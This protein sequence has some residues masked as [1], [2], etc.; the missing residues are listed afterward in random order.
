MLSAVRRFPLQLVGHRAPV[1]H[2]HS[3]T[4]VGQLLDLRREP[5]D[6]D[7][8]GGQPGDRRVELLLGADVDAARRVVEQH[9]LAA[10]LHPPA[11]DDLLLV[12]ARERADPLRRP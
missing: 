9:H 5:D 4:G 6:A 8:F 2:E 3:M 10:A 12:A 7:P 1:Q 11:E